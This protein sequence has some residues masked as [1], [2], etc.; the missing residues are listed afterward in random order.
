MRCH[1]LWIPNR[2]TPENSASGVV[3]AGATIVTL[4]AE[5]TRSAV[6]TP[7]IALPFISVAVALPASVRPATAILTAVVCAADAGDAAGVKT[8]SV[9]RMNWWPGCVPVAGSVW[10]NC[11]ARRS[12]SSAG[13]LAIRIVA[14]PFPFWS[15]RINGLSSKVTLALA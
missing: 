13:P 11:V 10:T 6:S 12:N 8:L 2:V 3:P 15:A 5:G 14:A 7:S 1:G 4:Y 9:R